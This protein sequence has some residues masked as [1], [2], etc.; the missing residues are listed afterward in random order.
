VLVRVRGHCQVALANPLADSRPR[1]AL[2]V[3][4]AD[5]SVEQVMR[6]EVRHALGVA[7]LGDRRA[8]CVGTAVVEQAGLG[9]TK[10]AMRQARLDRVD[11]PATT[12][13]GHAAATRSWS[14]SRHARCGLGP[15]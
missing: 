10:P 9:V 5:A 6:V 8:Q 1:P 13:H 15:S 14:T 12:L 7:C 2:R 4:Q 3:Q 11:V